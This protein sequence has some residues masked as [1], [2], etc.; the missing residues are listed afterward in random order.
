MPFEMNFSSKYLASILFILF[1]VQG[2]FLIKTTSPT[3]DEISFNMVNGYTYLKTHDYRMTPANPALIREWIALPWLFMDLKLDLTKRSWKEADSVPFGKEFFY[4]DNLWAAERLLFISRLMVLFLGLAMGIAVYFWAKELYGNKAGLLAL[5][6]YSFCPNILAHSALATT[7]IGVSLF[8]TLSAYFL[9]RYIEFSKTGDKWK[10]LWSFSF[11]CAAKFNAI[12]LGPV[13]LLIIVIK[14]GFIES[15]KCASSLILLAFFVIWASYGFEYKTILGGGVPRIAEKLVYLSDISHYLFPRNETLRIGFEK[16][17]E[18]T[19]IPIPSYILGMA[20]IVRGHQAP[21]MHYAFGQWT[22]DV[23]WY[24]YLF[25]FA[26]KMTLPALILLLCRAVFYKKC[27][28]VSSNENWVI[29]FSVV[30]VFAATLKD[31]TA[32]GIRYLLPVIPMLFVWLSGIARWSAS[33][34][35]IRKFTAIMVAV[36]LLTATPFFPH[37]ISYFNPL[38]GGQGYR[39]VRGSDVDWG[40]G[41]K[42]LASY[43]KKNGIQQI[44]LEYFGYTEPAYYGIRYEQLT[45]QEKIMPAKKV[46]AISLF[47]LEHV[48][49][50]KDIKP[51]AM[52][53]GSIFV[54]DL[55]R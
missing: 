17:I 36:N 54:Y 34:K 26:V 49:W 2:L 53:G 39:Y 15:A 18:R 19:P 6:F 28:S 1:F 47:Y 27:N 3:A 50:S 45:P 44:A 52:V 41:L 25:C 12:L 21:Y 22:T 13:F 14:K 38:V 30:A 48:Q 9:W 8:C 10:F 5:S 20:G 29:L 42:E 24:Y 4:K 46:Y 31:T 51:T 23:Q 35:V 32:V 43:L 37:Y 7:D 33:S 16:F 11:A 55:R 40:Q